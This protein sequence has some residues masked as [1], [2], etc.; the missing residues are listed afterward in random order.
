MQR[1]PRTVAGSRIP[2]EAGVKRIE[3]TGVRHRCRHYW[4]L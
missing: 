2:A 3:G 4:R 1:L